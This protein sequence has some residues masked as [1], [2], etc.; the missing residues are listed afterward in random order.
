MAFPPDTKLK[1]VNPERGHF[2]NANDLAVEHKRRSIKAARANFDSDYHTPSMKCSFSEASCKSLC[3]HDKCGVILVA[4]ARSGQR[5]VIHQRCRVHMPNS[6]HKKVYN[7]YKNLPNCG[8]KSGFIGIIGYT[9]DG[10]NLN[11]KSG[12]FNHGKTLEWPEF[13]QKFWRFY[14]SPEFELAV[15]TKPK[16]KA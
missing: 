6:D 3:P 14:G 8:E 4:S 15:S 16:L 13:E 2:S 5:T 12:T 9:V 1:D 7:E 10:R 11:L